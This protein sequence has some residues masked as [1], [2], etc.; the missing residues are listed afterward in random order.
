[1]TLTIDLNDSDSSTKA[2]L[3]PNKLFYEGLSG[4]TI[5]NIANIGYP[6]RG[7]EYVFNGWQV[8]SG[9]GTIIDNADGSKGFKFNNT[10]TVIKANWLHV[11]YAKVEFIDETD[12]NSLLSEKTGIQ[13]VHNSLVSSAYTTKTQD[14]KY[15]T[16]RGYTLVSDG[17]DA[18][19]KF[20]AGETITIQ[21]KLKHTYTTVD[22]DDYIPKKCLNNAC[23]AK[24]PETGC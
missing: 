18:N 24:E 7:S 23:T 14:I 6:T 3:N 16:D 1:M 8:V 13:G 12:N 2:T 19:P 4:T 5:N 20:T 15:W 21:I 9:D 22:K 11:G 17:F 10:D